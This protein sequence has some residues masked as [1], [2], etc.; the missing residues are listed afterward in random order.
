MIKG[1]KHT[2]ETRKRMSKSR[3]G[4]PHTTG[5]N[6]AGLKIGKWTILKR[7]SKIGE[8]EI[9]WRC[10][11]VCGRIKNVSGC[12]IRKGDSNG[13]L[14]CMKTIHGYKAKK[15]EYAMYNGA[16]YRAKYRGIEFSIKLQDIKIPEFCPLLGLPLYPAKKG[17]QPNSPT[18]DRRDCSKG[19]VKGNVWVISFRA[20]RIKSD[21]S[22]KELEMIVKN[23]KKAK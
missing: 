16:K 11:C 18:L 21:A 1:S 9:I 17:F 19:Y 15:Q 10:R 22:L 8:K 14:S 23:L 20:N 7:V 5:K 6:M 13:C 12:S 3:L 4:K 2:K